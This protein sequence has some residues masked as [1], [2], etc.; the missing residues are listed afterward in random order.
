[1][2]IISLTVNNKIKQRIKN[3]KMQFTVKE[4]ILVLFCT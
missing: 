1:M 4:N 3:P 2:I